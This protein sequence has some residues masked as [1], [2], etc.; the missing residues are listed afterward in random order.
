M[1]HWIDSAMSEQ[2]RYIEEHGK[3]AAKKLVDFYGSITGEPYLQF[4]SEKRCFGLLSRARLY[5][6]K[7]EEDLKDVFIRL[8]KKEKL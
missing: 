4:V 1:G 5:A 3:E 6:E 2:K 7:S 8:A